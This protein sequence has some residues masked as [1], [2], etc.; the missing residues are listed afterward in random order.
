MGFPLS[1]L[2]VLASTLA[3]FDQAVLLLCRGLFTPENDAIVCSGQQHL[4]ETA[5]QPAA[6]GYRLEGAF[7]EVWVLFL[8]L[9]GWVGLDHLLAGKMQ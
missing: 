7:T 5:F 2:T 6:G 1:L 4:Y 9:K 3:V 8:L